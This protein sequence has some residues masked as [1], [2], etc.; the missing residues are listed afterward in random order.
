[1]KKLV[2]G[3]TGILG[4]GKSAV[5]RMLEKKGAL[6]IDMDEAG[7]HV[8]DYDLLVQQQLLQTFGADIFDDRGQLRRR[9][10]GDK[11]FAD[12][13][14][15]A[16]LNAIVH[17]A[18]LRRVHQQIDEA[19]SDAKGCC[20]VVDAALIFELSF[21][22]FCDLMIVVEAPLETC[23][24][25]AEQHKNLTRDQALRRMDAQWSQEQKLSRADYALVNDASL[26]ILEKRIND[27]FAWLISQINQRKK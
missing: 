20:I 5:A 3:L 7:R 15:L 11:V 12:E 24:Q 14:S 13:K 25:R 9:L 18:M 10:L 21:D 26:G 4:S 23:L 22:Q 27:L 19:Q 1:M 17:P 2:V 8:V 6:V 16:R